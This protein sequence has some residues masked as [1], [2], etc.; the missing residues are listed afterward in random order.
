MAYLC[1]KEK[2]KM[3]E[4]KMELH[5]IHIYQPHKL[6]YVECRQRKVGKEVMQC[7]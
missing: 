3:Y 5:Y 2:I 4:I 6:R 1:D 7:R